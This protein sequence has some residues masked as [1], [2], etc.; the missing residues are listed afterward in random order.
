MEAGPCWGTAGA[1]DRRGW[2]GLGAGGLDRGQAATRA[3]CT[4]TLE[5]WVLSGSPAASDPCAARRVLLGVKLQSPLLPAEPTPSPG[6][7]LP[8]RDLSD[9]RSPPNTKGSEGLGTSDLHLGSWTPSV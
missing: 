5:T 7:Q 8:L 9:Q 4:W 2:A 1:E 6:A 3:Q